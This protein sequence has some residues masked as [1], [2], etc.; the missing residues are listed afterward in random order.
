MQV[1]QIEVRDVERER[2]APEHHERVLEQ[3][4][5][6]SANA[7]KIAAGPSVI[8]RNNRLG[9]YFVVLRKSKNVASTRA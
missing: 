3:P 9:G 8:A 4:R 1:Q 2:H 7:Q 6:C 5:H